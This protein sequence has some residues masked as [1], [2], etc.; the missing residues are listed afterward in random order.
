MKLFHKIF[1]CFV[2][3]FGIAFQAAGVLL[4]DY[5]YENAIEQ[6]KKYALQ[7]FQYNK[8]ILQ[9]VLYS[10]PDLLQAQQESPGSLGSF[11]T[12]VALYDQEK[13]CIYSDLSIKP[14]YLDFQEREEGQLAFR[15]YQKDRNSCIFVYDH[16]RQGEGEA[17]LVTQ[18]DISSVVETQ[19][20]MTAYFQRIYLIIVCIG[21]P[22]IFLLTNLLT[23]SIKKVS[24]GARRIARGKYAERIDVGT[25]DEIGQ[26]AADF[27]QMAEKI[28]EK[29][30]QLS[31]AARAKEDF[32]A[33]FAHE[34]KTPLTSVI[35]YA[36][37]LYQRELPRKQVKE[38]AGYILHEGMRLEALSLKLMD[39]FVMDK[40]DFMLEKQETGGLFENMLP[41]VKPV[42]EKHG[43][44]LHTDIEE[45]E[46]AVEFDLF[47]TMALNIIDNA[48]KAECSDIWI[49]GEKQQ[50][51]Y[52]ISFKDNGKGIPPAELGR[53][54]EAFYMVDKSRSRKQHGAGLGMA[55]VAK[56]AQL[57]TAALRVESDGRSG[58]TVRIAFGLTEGGRDEQNV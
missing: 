22:L 4:I 30:S 57:H 41:G 34:L 9:S 5:A 38:A 11:T 33:N 43:V 3:I 55:L 40:Q 29:M 23:G 19:R 53:I 39:L 26:L 49:T 50:T 36:D 28:E 52:Q 24:K 47:K 25:K 10:E 18:T 1:L 20:N 51:G 46:I 48:V 7:Q 17:Y 21:F 16:V 13:N 27:N 2:V 54:T 12:P 45:G 37:M 32:T 56:I 14:V 6:E 15:I 58:T 8:Y 31:A 35:G 44:Q 42:C